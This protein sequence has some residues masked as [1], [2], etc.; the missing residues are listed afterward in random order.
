MLKDSYIIIG[1]LFLCTAGV[2]AYCYHSASNERTASVE[3]QNYRTEEK[4]SELESNTT[5]NTTES[6]EELW[7]TKAINGFRKDYARFLSK[8]HLSKEKEDRF[9]TLAA[10]KAHL[11][12]ER[13]EGLKSGRFKSLQEANQF[14][15]DAKKNYDDQIR[16]LLGD[17]LYNQYTSATNRIPLTRSMNLFSYIAT[18]HN[19]PFSDQQVDTI[20][21]LTLD[22]FKQTGA[23]PLFDP[24][25]TIATDAQYFSE[26]RARKKAYDI[27]AVQAAN[28]LSPDQVA[29]LKQFL[30]NQTEGWMSMRFGKSKF[31]NS[32]MRN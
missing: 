11:F 30:D 16:S 7:Y 5:E 9:L 20:I 22:A 27:V 8:A 21:D 24:N 12:N 31:Y 32:A 3:R 6:P 4:S 1:S 17:E 28:S 14:H 2:G 29:F 19:V 15:K 13:D 23:N 18:R 10:H 25:T 26:T